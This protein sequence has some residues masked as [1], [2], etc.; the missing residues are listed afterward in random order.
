MTRIP[1]TGGAGFIGQHTIRLLEEKGYD[2][3][4]LDWDPMRVRDLKC[5]HKITGDMKSQPLIDALMHE[6]KPEGI[7]HLGAQ[8][9]VPISMLAWGL[10]AEQNI[11]GTISVVDAARRNG[12]KRIVF[13]GSGGSVYGNPT[14]LPVREDT[15][16]N[17]LSPYAISKLAGEFY[18]RISGLS[19]AILRYPNVYGPEQDPKGA[20]G[21]VAIFIGKMMVDEPCIIYGD[22]HQ[23][24]DYVY[25]DDVAGANVMA[26]ESQRDG[27]FNIG[28]GEGV[29]VNTIHRLIAEQL[30]KSIWPKNEEARV[31]EVRK[32]Y[33]DPS[34]ANKELNWRP[35]V[36]LEEGIKRTI[37]H[38]AD[39]RR[40]N[41]KSP[42]SCGGEAGSIPARAINMN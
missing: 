17:P 8:S 12:V 15:S 3:V 26:L 20:A 22:G 19:H 37:E 21:V 9:A 14:K 4:A 42:L 6:Y 5:L 40:T 39:A 30:G 13:A 35:M 33:L 11:M 34:K 1:V 25:V 18:V 36:G 2:V 41:G 38:V 31:G 23:E 29:T 28:T 16:V 24:R 7:I 27:I 10:D 32:V